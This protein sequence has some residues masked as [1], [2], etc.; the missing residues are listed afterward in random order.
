MLTPLKNRVL[1]KIREADP[2][3]PGGICIPKA[4]APKSNEGRVVSFGPDVSDL[5]VGDIVLM[6]TFGGQEIKIDDEKHVIIEDDAIL[7]IR[8]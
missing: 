5:K 1:V 3:T 6:P 4:H 2:I 8:S 7:A